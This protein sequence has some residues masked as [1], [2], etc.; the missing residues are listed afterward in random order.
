MGAKETLCT[1]C[2]HRDIC[3]KKDQYLSIVPKIDDITY[4]GKNGGIAKLCDS[5]D[6]QVDLI[7]KHY[8]K[9]M[10]YREKDVTPDYLRSA[11]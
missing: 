10:I 5:N 4:S 6:F 11:T 2:S 7:C 3:S 9:H 8:L 1:E